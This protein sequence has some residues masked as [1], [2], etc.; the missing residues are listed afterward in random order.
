MNSTNHAIQG[1]TSHYLTAGRL[2]V[3]I[4]T[5]LVGFS[6]ALA[7]KKEVTV[8]VEVGVGPA[9]HIVFGDMQKKQ[10]FFY[11]A[12][13]N[14]EAVIDKALI[15]QNKKKIPKKYRKMA[16]KLNEVRLRPG[17]LAYIPKT[18]LISPGDNAM[19]GAIWDLVGVGSGFG[20]LKLSADLQFA[21]AYLSY[22][23]E[24]EGATQSMHLIRPALAVS[25][26]I[27]VML[28]DSFGFDIGWRSSLMPPQ[29]LGGSPLSFSTDLEGTIWHIGQAYF[30][31]T[32][33]IPYTTRM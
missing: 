21:Y 14:L 10:D 7:K 19:Y 1:G 18:L 4:L 13:I 28:T 24:T 31:L 32:F 20:P 26:H 3:M 33:R 5:C 29:E 11:G 12:R 25:A 27:P 8:P 30:A 6:P 17:P 22:Q 23:G 9:G 16:M 2:T 15:K